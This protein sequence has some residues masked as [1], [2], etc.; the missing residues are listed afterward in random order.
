MADFFESFHPKIIH[1]YHRD[2]QF[3]RQHKQRIASRPTR[4]LSF[5]YAYSGHG[6]MELDG[7]PHALGP[8][9][10]F[11]I[12]YSR[13]LLLTTPEE[14]PLC[15]YTVQYDFTRVEWD[16]DQPC[17]QEPEHKIL[18][19]P[20]LVP[21]AD[22]TGM[23]TAMARLYAIWNERRPDHVGQAKLAFLSVLQQTQ[24]H[25]RRSRQ[26]SPTEQAIRESAAYINQHYY[27]QLDR[28]SLA[29]L[30]S[31]TGSYYS[32][33]FKRYMGCT[34]VSYISRVRM[35]K[36]M[37]LLKETNLPIAEV[38]RQVGFEDALY[39]TRVFSRAVGMTPRA[40]RNG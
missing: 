3:W 36:A 33:L 12:P 22:R 23:E 18:P 14:A 13:H 38:A 39:F 35:D 8:G 29:R 37:Q 19:F 31:L 11:Q 21:L 16:G 2:A 1:V 9:Y 32:V 26:Q 7:E 28:D 25:L 4:L 10:A 24:A 15:Y 34:L 6:V 17:C 5:V 30:A 40:F 27:E 20:L